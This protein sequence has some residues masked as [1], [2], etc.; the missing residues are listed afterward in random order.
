L[1]INVDVAT[2]L[3]TPRLEVA[4]FADYAS[5]S[6]QD[7]ISIAGIFDRILI[8]KDTKQSNGFFI[9]VRTAETVRGNIQI[10]LMA[11]DHTPVAAVIYDASAKKF[12]PGQPRIV[13][14]L[15]RIAFKATV[16]GVYWLDVSYKEQSLGGTGLIV[17]F[18]TTEKQD[19]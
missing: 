17:E 6:K 12:S 3:A 8:D 5:M 19:G 15:D 10:T 7:K 18:K 11:P 4:A 9:F 2:A 13:Q 16:E 14:F 1:K